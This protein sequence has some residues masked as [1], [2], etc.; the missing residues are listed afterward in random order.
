MDFQRHMNCVVTCN[1]LLT[2][3]VY[4][5]INTKHYTMTQRKGTTESNDQQKENYTMTQRKSKTKK[6]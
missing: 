4:T 6:L 3:T 2:I 5:V 1:E